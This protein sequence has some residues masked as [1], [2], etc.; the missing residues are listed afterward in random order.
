M[1]FLTAR[2]NAIATH[3]AD[4]INTP[5]TVS[6][7][8][9]NR[10][11]GYMQNSKPLSVAEVR[12]MLPLGQRLVVG[13]PTRWDMRMAA[14]HASELHPR[15]VIKQTGDTM[16]TQYEGEDRTSRMDWRGHCA[17]LDLDTGWIHIYTP[18]SDLDVAYL[19]LTEGAS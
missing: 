12:R 18:E 1:C 3:R 7:L 16:V 4:S 13:Y 19:P 11:R 9:T 15:T 2:A 5:G 17:Q 6:S 10:E 14:N 8:N